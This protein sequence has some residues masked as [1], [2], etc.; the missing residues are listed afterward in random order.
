MGRI[1]GGTVPAD[2]RQGRRWRFASA[3]FDEVRWALFV[4]GHI[5]PIEAKPLELMHELLL[6]AGEAVSKDELLDAV[7]PEVAVVEASLATAVFKL[8]HA[9]GDDGDGSR[10]IETVP[11]I[12]YRLAVPVEVENSSPSATKAHLAATLVDAPYDSGRTSH[13][14]AARLLRFPVAVS[15]VAIAF[16]VGVILTVE[17]LRAPLARAEPAFT[18]LDAGNALRRLDV[19]AVEKLLARGWDPNKPFDKVGDN[20]LMVLFQVCERDPGHDQRKML[21]V[22][23]TLVDD[24]IRLETR[25]AFGDTAY[26]IAKAKR[27]CGPDHPATRMLH[28]VCYT[29]GGNI[30]GDKC[31]ASYELERRNKKRRQPET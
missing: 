27:Y 17:A 12:G 15:A 24:G 26:S 4:D 13:W 28:T 20:A 19:T 18:Q 1:K 11:R 29:G 22:V 25:N 23:Q 14:A 2:R 10:I 21:L 30:L 16:L 8:R 5:V 9:L 31:L 3:V 7:W 6:R